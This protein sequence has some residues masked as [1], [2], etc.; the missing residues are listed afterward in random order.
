M[1]HE[2]EK[3]LV[4]ACIQKNVVYLQS[5]IGNACTTVDDISPSGGADMI[6]EGINK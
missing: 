6:V 1:P 2:K 4:Y 3:I 5:S